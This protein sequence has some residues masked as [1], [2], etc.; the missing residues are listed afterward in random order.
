MTEGADP[1]HEAGAAFEKYVVGLFGGD[2][3]ILQWMGQGASREDIDAGP[4]LVVEHL[5]TGTVFGVECKY[6]ATLF[7]GRLGWA[8]EYQPA[9]YRRYAEATGRRVFVVI[10]VGGSPGRPD[11]LYC[12]PLW[13]AGRNRLDPAA[14]KRYRRGPRRKFAYDA[15]AGGLR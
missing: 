7:K 12:L 9:K 11:Y 5:P 4:D 2:F 6:R 14:L 3:R 8:K 13:Q 15:A 10:G 1:T